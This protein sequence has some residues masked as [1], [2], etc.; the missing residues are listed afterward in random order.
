VTKAPEAEKVVPKEEPTP[1][2]EATKVSPILP[3]LS[4]EPPELPDFEITK[5]FLKDEVKPAKQET[6]QNEVV[7]KK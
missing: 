3:A 6:P 5:N 7:V 4:M 1:K 2:Q